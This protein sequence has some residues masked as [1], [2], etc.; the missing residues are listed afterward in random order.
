MWAALLV[1]TLATPVAPV[2]KDLSTSLAAAVK[3]VG[4]L[5]R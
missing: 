4:S 3:A 1:G 5:K 2:A